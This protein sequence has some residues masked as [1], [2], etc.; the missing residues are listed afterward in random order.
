[1]PKIQL[2]HFQIIVVSQVGN[3]TF[4]ICRKIIDDIVIV[5]DN[6]IINSIFDIFNDIRIIPEPAGA[7][8]TAGI[9]KYIK[10]NNIKNKTFV[11]LISGS[12]I[13]IK[14]LNII[15]KNI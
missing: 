8:A 14:K 7:L 13:D 15:L 5:D 2:I 11:S 1:M 3:N 10:N 9:N 4:E 12:N 6:E